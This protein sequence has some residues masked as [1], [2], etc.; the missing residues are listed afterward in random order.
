MKFERRP[1]RSVPYHVRV[2]TGRETHVGGKGRE[3]GA[4]SLSL[5]FF[6]SGDSDKSPLWGR[7]S[8]P[9]A[10]SIRGRINLWFPGAATSRRPLLQ[11]VT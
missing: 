1:R 7:H 8:R 5:S 3:R 6:L 10:F 11:G 2:S 4:K 9:S